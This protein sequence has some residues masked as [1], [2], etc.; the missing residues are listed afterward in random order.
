MKNLFLASYLI[1]QGMTH[2]G[3][4]FFISFTVFLLLLKLIPIWLGW[5]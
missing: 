4:V 1:W 3:K 5:R 2:I